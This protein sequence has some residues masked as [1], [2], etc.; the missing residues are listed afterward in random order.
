MVTRTDPELWEKIK[1]KVKRSAKFGDAN[2]WNARKA[3]HAVKL[4]KEAGGGYVGAK[5]SKNSLVKW[6]KQD[7]QY[8]SEDGKGRYLPKKVWEK[9]SPQEKAATNRKKKQATKKHKK[10]AKYSKKVAKLVREA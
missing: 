10:K 6:T 9:L 4:Y 3:Q 2:T 7:W 1:K 5:S 8:S